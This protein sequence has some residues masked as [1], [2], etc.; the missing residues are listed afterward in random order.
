MIKALSLCLII[1]TGGMAMAQ[2]L[3]VKSTAF[4]NGGMIPKEFTGEGRDV[5]PPLTWSGAP[6]TTKSFALICDDP[7]TSVGTWVHWV[8]FNI[9]STTISLATGIKGSGVEGNNSWPT[10]G[11]KGPM[12]P[13][14]SGAHRYFFKVYA[15]DTM[16]TLTAGATKD[17]LEQAMKGHVVA[18]GQWMGKF[19]R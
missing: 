7:D 13:P 1:L 14:G 18:E 5:S 10:L 16:L 3:V 15:L 6:A 19:S 9:P 2:T 17:K 11:Y 8:L 12:P 4:D